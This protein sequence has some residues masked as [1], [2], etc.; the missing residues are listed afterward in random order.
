MITMEQN[1]KQEQCKQPTREP[2]GVPVMAEHTGPMVEK[3]GLS[4]PSN[5]AEFKKDKQN[6]PPDPTTPPPPKKKKKPPHKTERHKT[7]ILTK[8][9]TTVTEPPTPLD[10]TKFHAII[11][12]QHRKD[13][14]Y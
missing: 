1:I 7:P 8:E 5:Q 2:H 3:K 14:I 11:M 6:T 4:S 9:N 12:E 13:A 10:A